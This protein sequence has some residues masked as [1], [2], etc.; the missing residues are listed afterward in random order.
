MD[1]LR[2]FYIGLSQ[3]RNYTIG[4]FRQWGVAGN[5]HWIIAQQGNSSFN[6]AGF[7]NVD[8]Y[9]IEMLGNIQTTYTPSSAGIVSDYSFQVGITGQNQLISGD[10]QLSPNFWNISSNIQQFDLG[11]YSNKIFFDSPFSGCTK[12]SFT[13]IKIQGQNGETLNLLNLDLRLQFKFLYKY[14]GE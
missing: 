13:E 12:I 14:E 4:Q 7:K 6:I 5:Y 10:V 1:C 8:L 3:N 9:G 11:K 2:S